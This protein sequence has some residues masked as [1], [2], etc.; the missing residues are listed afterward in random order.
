LRT[1]RD[2][3]KAKFEELIEGFITNRVGISESFL[4]LPLA[5][6]MQQ[7]IQRLSRD[8]RMEWAGIGNNPKDKNQKVRGDR[9]CWIDSK[10]KNAHEMEFLDMI[11]QFTEHLN[12]TCFT[13]IN[14]CE[15]HYALYEEG[16]SYMKHRDQFKNDYNR[17]YSMIGYLNNDWVEADGGQLIIHHDEETTQTILPNSQKA[18]F[19]QSDQIEHE[20]AVANRQR[21]SVSGWLKRV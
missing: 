5:A 7:N 12:R 3:M 16:A 20:V 19:F 17:K 9:T 15:F 18:V 1:E 11:R 10:T 2:S 4:A 21:M 6:G 14:S 13:G 8:S